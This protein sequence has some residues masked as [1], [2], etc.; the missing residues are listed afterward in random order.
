[1]SWCCKLEQ[2]WDKTIKLFLGLTNLDS[3]SWKFSFACQNECICTNYEYVKFDDLCDDIRE[4]K[5]NFG[6]KKGCTA[7]LYSSRHAADVTRSDQNK[8]RKFKYLP[9]QGILLHNN[10]IKLDSRQIS[11]SSIDSETK[12][13]PAKMFWSLPK[14]M[15]VNSS[16]KQ[17]RRQGYTTRRIEGHARGLQLYE[18]HKFLYLHFSYHVR[19][20]L[21]F[22]ILFLEF[23]LATLSYTHCS[24]NVR[25][26]KAFV[27]TK[28]LAS[29]HIDE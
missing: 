14:K 22:F 9:T 19:N 4:K 27:A 5:H 8:K 20:E 15:E 23:G 16:R 26:F 3:A 12:C 6:K 1:M 18:P 17:C 10:R 24:A 7:A 21:L 25:S 13:G 11:R 29:F 28:F 2:V